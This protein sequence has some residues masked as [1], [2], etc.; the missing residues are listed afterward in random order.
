MRSI[1]TLALAVA[2][3]V[4]VATASA[5]SIT[6]GLYNL[7][8][9]P[10]GAAASPFYGLRLDGLFNGNQNTTVTFDFEAPGADMKME[11]DLTPGD[12]SIHIYGTAW[13]G[14][15]NGSSYT[16]PALFN[17]DF[18]Y[19]DIQVD[20]DA[21]WAIGINNTGTIQEVGS[22]TTL[23]NLTAVSGEHTYAFKLDD[24]HRGFSGISGWGWVNHAPAP[25]DPATVPH[26]YASDWLFTAEKSTVPPPPVV[27]TPAGFAAGLLGLAAL[28]AR[29]GR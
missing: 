18:T 5:S 24:G 1:T 20:G 23:Y 4:P 15:D 27:P 25:T 14:I 7:S 10:D 26:L 22:G 19:V 11:I 29:R 28:V 6:S 3:L 12:S 9:H 16:S 8:N 21:L 2:L 13:G 17:I